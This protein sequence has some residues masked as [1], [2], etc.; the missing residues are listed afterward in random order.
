MKTKLLLLLLVS[1][2][3][4]L[5][6]ERL[7]TVS[8]EQVGMSLAQLRYADQAINQAIHDGQTPGAV[9]AVVRHGK[10]AYLK[11]YGNRQTYPSTEPMTPNTIFDMASCTK[12]MA[13]ALS[14]M[15]LVER[16]LLRINDP[17][18]RYLP[19]FKSWNS[20]NKDSADIRIIDLLTHTS[21]LPAYASVNTLQ[22]QFGTPNPQKLMQYIAQC[23]RDFKPETAMQ[24]SCLN[25]ITLQ[26][27]VERVSK[28]SLR[29]FAA[30][31]IFIPLGMNHTDFL[32]CSQDKNGRWKSISA[33]RWIKNGERE[34][35]TP[36][37][38]TEK[39][40]DG[41]VKKGQVHDPLACV[42]NG[43][44]SHPL[45]NATKWWNMGWKTDSQSTH[46]EGHA[47]RSRRFR[48]FRT[49]SR[50]GCIFPLCLQQR[51]FTKFRSLRTHRLYRHFDCY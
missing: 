21:G 32:P 13:T 14:V 24:Y 39:Q 44:C 22:K 2:A 16:G 12:P 17:V 43:G 26:N 27:I 51:R 18:K 36:I 46:S 49:Q 19:E 50:L 35:V 48:H 47:H 33:P 8:P 29:T 1:F 30:E 38:P 7:Q 34:G 11:A 6:A 5:R 42:V 28:Q 10:L 40:T 25:Y 15:I 9:L 45:R 20:S 37:A 4:T 31:N 23:Q 3:T 41:S